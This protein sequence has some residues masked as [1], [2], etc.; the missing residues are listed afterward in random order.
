MNNIGKEIE[1]HCYKH[2]GKID[3]ISCGSIILDEAKDYL[4]CANERVNIIE[5]DGHKHKTKEPA[6]I[7]F[8]KNN[9]FNIIAQFKEFGLFYYCNIAS[10]YIIEDELSDL[11][12]IKYIDYDLDLR[13]F[14]DGGHIVLDKNEYQFHKKV[15]N[16]SEKLDF[17][18]HK[19]LEKL[20][21]MKENNE[22]PFNID[23][24]DY[25]FK[26]YKKIKK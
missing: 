11:P 10:P 15:M 26:V 21:N 22:G 4:I 5:N 9:W 13:V 1:I 7:F 3:T 14:P 24:I 18:I 20:I 23:T 8:Y 17:V 6:V 25:Y 12:I 19:E 16:Y 2:N